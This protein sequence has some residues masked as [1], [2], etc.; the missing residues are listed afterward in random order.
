MST[1]HARQYGLGRKA[2]SQKQSKQADEAL[3]PSSHDKN[4]SPNTIL[5][6][7]LTLLLCDCVFLVIYKSR[8]LAMQ[9]VFD[10]E[11]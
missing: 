8:H 5:C 4:I 2:G 7:R 3:I 10:W 1:S 11:E 6:V 9:T